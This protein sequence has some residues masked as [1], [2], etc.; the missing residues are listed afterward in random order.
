M[1]AHMESLSTFC[2]SQ[3][4]ARKLPRAITASAFFF[5]TFGSRIYPLSQYA[6][7]AFSSLVPAYR[8]SLG[9]SL[10]P[11]TK[12]K[13]EYCLPT[14]CLNDHNLLLE[15]NWGIYKTQP[16]LLLLSQANSILIYNH[17][18]TVIQ[19]ALVSYWPFCN[20]EKQQEGMQRFR[21]C[22]LHNTFMLRRKER[23]NEPLMK[24][25]EIRKACGSH[26]QPL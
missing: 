8:W 20:L 24:F 22:W 16:W 9:V 11:V 26:C 17:P 14:F 1:T 23:E 19:Q 15:I 3:Q 5:P 18:V 2:L 12:G 6:Y 25:L 13:K 21:K 7:T 4:Y 10:T